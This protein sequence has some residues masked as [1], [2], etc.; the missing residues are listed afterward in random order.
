MKTLVAVALT[1]LVCS[2]GASSQLTD[3]SCA[4]ALAHKNR[5][6]TKAAEGRRIHAD[7]IEY[8]NQGYATQDQIR[9]G[10]TVEHHQQWINNYDEMLYVLRN[11]R[12]S[13]S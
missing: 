3:V 4:D 11:A 8:I 2:A 7:W 9:I 6:I 12:I 1:A 10:G 5:A 13:C